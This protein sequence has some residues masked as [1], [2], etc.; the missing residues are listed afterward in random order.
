MTARRTLLA[1]T[2]A[3]GGL[4]LLL[5]SSIVIGAGPHEYSR[6]A[7]SA[8]G[9]PTALCLSALQFGRSQSM[10]DVHLRVSRDSRGWYAVDGQVSGP[11]L[12]AEKVHCTV[13]P[14]PKSEG[15]MRVADWSWKPAGDTL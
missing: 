12:P 4:V 6:P 1:V 7:M 5:E 14:D 9:I 15:G 11:D 10:E 13:V 2:A 3:V 8:A